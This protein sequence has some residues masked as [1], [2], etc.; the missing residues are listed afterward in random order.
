[1]KQLF[2]SRKRLKINTEINEEGS[3]DP[4]RG[5]ALLSDLTS[6]DFYNKSMSIAVVA[7]GIKHQMCQESNDLYSHSCAVYPQ[8]VQSV[9][10]PC[11]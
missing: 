9:L 4:N 1:M 2:H 7:W 10:L 3:A 6:Q 8:C 11:A 5:H